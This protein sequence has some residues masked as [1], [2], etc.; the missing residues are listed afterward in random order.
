[1]IKDL[2]LE[3]WLEELAA[4]SATP[5]GGS[6][7]AMAGAMAGALVAMVCGVTAAKNVAAEVRTSLTAARERADKLRR[8]MAALIDEDVTVFSAVMAAYALPRAS[9]EQQA[10]RSSAIQAALHQATLVPLACAEAGLTALE[11][12]GIVSEQG[13]LNAIGESAVAAEAARMA[14]RASALN[15]SINLGSIRDQVFVDSQ[16]AELERLQRRF[17]ELDGRIQE[18]LAKRLG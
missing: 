3:R 8:R 15:V 18:L 1:L 4:P 10:A 2:S 13:H 6:A 14:F 16:R 9:A 17:V 5:G 7:T 11:L 12:A